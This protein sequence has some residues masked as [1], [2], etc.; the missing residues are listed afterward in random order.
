MRKEGYSDFDNEIKKIIKENG[1]ECA[2]TYIPGMN[3]IDSD[4]FE[5]R[6]NPV[7]YD[8][9]MILFKNKMMGFDIF[10]ARINLFFNKLFKEKR[11]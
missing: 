6:R 7:T 11:P 10:P 1:F 3:D 8:T 2:L 4:L 5:L 9:D